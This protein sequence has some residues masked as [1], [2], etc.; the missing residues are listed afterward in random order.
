[1]L[2]VSGLIGLSKENALNHVEEASRNGSDINFKKRCMADCHV[3]V[4]QQAKGNVVKSLVLDMLIV[5]GL[6]GLRREA[7]LK[8][9]EVVFRNGPGINFKKVKMED[10]LVVE[11]LLEKQV[12]IHNPVQVRFF[13]HT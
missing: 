10:Y 11:M 4:I 7:A 12:A 2:I 13:S 8:L 3:V 6:N 1:M 9:V 5:N